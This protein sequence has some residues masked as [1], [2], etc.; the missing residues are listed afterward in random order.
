MFLGNKYKERTA[1]GWSEEKSLGPLFQQIPIM[2]LTASAD[3]TYVFDE[4]EE[5]GTIRYSRL[6]DGKREQPKAFGK[7]INSGK[8]TGHPFIAA[9]ESYLIWD[10]ERDGGFGGVDLYISFRQDDNSWGAAINM[11]ADINT[12]VDNAY[13]SVTSDEKYLFFHSVKVSTESFSEWEANIFWVDA[14]I[15]ETL[16]PK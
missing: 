4:R 3:N 14:Q 16:R 12:E 7:N 11:G 2:R 10:S 6:V 8:W 1:S 5:I 9:D 15:I 13:G